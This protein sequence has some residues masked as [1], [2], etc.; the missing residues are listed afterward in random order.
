MKK[1]SRRSGHIHA[2]K[3][4]SITV[5]MLIRGFKIRGLKS[6]L[7]TFEHY[8]SRNNYFWNE[9]TRVFTEYILI[10]LEKNTQLFEYSKLIEAV[11]NICGYHKQRVRDISSWNITTD[12]AEQQLY[13]LAKHMFDMHGDVPDFLNKY[14][15]SSYHR[16]DINTPYRLLY[17]YLGS[18]KGITKYNELPV[19]VTSKL[20][21]HFLAAPETCTYKN[22]IIYANIMSIGGSNEMYY[23]LINTNWAETLFSNVFW[24]TVAAFIIKNPELDTDNISEICSYINRIKFLRYAPEPGFEIKG[25]TAESLIRKA[26]EL[27]NKAFNIRWKPMPINGCKLRNEDSYQRKYIIEQITD[28]VSLYEEGKAMQNCVN[29]YLD[30]CYDGYCSIWSLYG[31][32]EN[33]GIKKLVTIEVDTNKYIIQAK[34]KCNRIITNLEMSIIR[35]WAEQEGLEIADYVEAED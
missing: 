30:K 17:I 23:K 1:L 34:G 9:H 8:I 21:K 35:Q 33:T 22:A 14:W 31:I 13:C 16:Q 3:D 25:R 24:R 4:D 27:K 15:M 6:G 2:P 19:K 5:K 26:R 12:N 18:G 32:S 20:A 7:S 28:K 10:L 29:T 11:Y